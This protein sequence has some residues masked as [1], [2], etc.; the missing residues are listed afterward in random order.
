MYLPR[1]EK[2]IYTCELCEKCK[3]AR[4][5]DIHRYD[6]TSALLEKT[7][8]DHVNSYNQFKGILTN[9]LFVSQ[10][11]D[12]V[13]DYVYTTLIFDKS[14]YDDISKIRKLVQ[15]FKYGFG[16]HAITLLIANSVRIMQTLNS[17]PVDHGHHLH[18]IYKSIF[19]YTAFSSLNYIKLY[20][21][22]KYYF[23]NLQHNCS[24]S[25]YYSRFNFDYDVQTTFSFDYDVYTTLPT[26]L[27]I[28][29]KIVH[30]RHICSQMSQSILNKCIIHVN[31]MY[32][33]TFQHYSKIT[34]N[35]I[36]N[37]FDTMHL[38]L[39][40]KKE[41]DE[42]NH[43]ISFEHH[44]NAKHNFSTYGIQPFFDK[45]TETNT[46]NSNTSCTY[47]AKNDVYVLKEFANTI[48]NQYFVKITIFKVCDYEQL[49]TII[50]ISNWFRN[51]LKIEFNHIIH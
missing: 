1:E 42:I 35:E 31:D 49:Y 7:I 5:C 45:I 47:D 21:E 14:I 24:L 43:Y 25:D 27:H 13:L 37:T 40:T 3:I 38:K 26:L 46:C 20:V 22:R 17:L 28:D 6:G 34:D 39:M 51:L 48:P 33:C 10:I 19:K 4:P 23:V 44:R 8:S 12:Y 2:T 30:Y 36:K 9:Y 15:Y 16:D 50:Q 11:A 18:D 32:G 41:N 29:E